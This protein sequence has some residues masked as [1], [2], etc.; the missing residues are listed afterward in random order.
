MGS[1]KKVLKKVKKAVKK[2]ISKAFKGIA[3][4]IMKVGKAT[5]RGIASLNKKLGPIGSIALSIAMPY[6]LSGLSNMIGRGAMLV[7]LLEL[8]IMQLL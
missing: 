6:A 3:K 8:V 5:I 7:M 4:G 2:P 1:I